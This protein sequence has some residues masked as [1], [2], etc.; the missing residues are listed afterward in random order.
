MADNPSQDLRSEAERLRSE[1]EELRLRLEEAE[2]AL[3]AIR[4]GQVESLIVEGPNGPRI[5]SLEGAD[6]SYRVLVEAMNEGAATLSE[7]G[8]ILYCNARCSTL[9]SSA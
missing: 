2:Q 9:R 7:D 1:V 5:F 8:T 3:E 4:T 6:H